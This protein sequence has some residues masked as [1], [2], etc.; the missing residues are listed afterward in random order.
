MGVMCGGYVRGL[1]GGTGNDHIH[2]VPDLTAYGSFGI[3]DISDRVR[4]RYGR[5][6]PLI[7]E[8]DMRKMR[9]FRTIAP[10]LTRTGAATPNYLV[11]T[12]ITPLLSP[13]AFLRLERGKPRKRKPITLPAVSILK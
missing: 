10:H 4:A 7:W 1:R 12:E 3:M 5:E 8:T 13:A 11:G 6:A 9:E 2:L